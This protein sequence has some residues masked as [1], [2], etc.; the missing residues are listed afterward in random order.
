MTTDEPLARQA[1]WMGLAYLAIIGL[2]LFSEL[3]VRGS[4]VVP[5]DA[6]ATAQ[7]IAAAPLLWR[8]GLV[9]DLAMHVLDVPLIVFFYFVLRPAGESLAL[10]ATGLNIVQTAVLA[11]DRTH[12]L[13]PLFVLEPA[14]HVGAFSAAQL[15]AMSQLAINMHGHGFGIGLI[16]FG[17][18]CVLRA[19][20]IWRSGVL[21]RVLGVGLGLAGVCYLVN[22]LA[23]LLAP[24]LARALFP[25][26]LLPPLVGELALSLWL[27]IRGPRAL[28][29]PAADTAAADTA[30]AGTAAAPR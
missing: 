8:C 2:G 11:F 27:L 21:P 12:L 26:V 19:L 5:G 22:S 10:T 15:Q 24:P 28:R 18:A 14:T 9:A 23:L 7:R 17:V 13:T 3:G 29:W 20:L 16:Y 25:A 1:R 30:A 4:L 6:A